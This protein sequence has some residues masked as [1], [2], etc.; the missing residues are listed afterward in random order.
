[1]PSTDAAVARVAVSSARDSLQPSDST[2]ASAPAGVVPS[3]AEAQ[4]VADSV[5]VMIGR[6]VVRM[7][8]LLRTAGDA[9]TQFQGFLETNSP[10][11]KLAG[12]PSVSSISATNAKVAIGLVLQWEK[13]EARRERTVN[14][15]CVVEAVPGGWAIREIRFPNGFT[16]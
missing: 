10:S 7:S 5:I 6:Q 16:P 9:G 12:A 13:A 2:T 15:E 11:A 14:I 8:L 3:E 4:T 1:M